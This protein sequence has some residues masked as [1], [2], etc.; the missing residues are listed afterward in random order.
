M[1]KYGYDE[2]KYNKWKLKIRN[3]NCFSHDKNF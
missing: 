1:I 2:L 3:E